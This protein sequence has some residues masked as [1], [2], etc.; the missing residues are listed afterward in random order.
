[1]HSEQT[2]LMSLQEGGF[3]HMD[4]HTQGLLNDEKQKEDCLLLVSNP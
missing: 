1:M 3:G 4:K 2:G